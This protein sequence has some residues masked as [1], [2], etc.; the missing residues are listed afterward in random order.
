MSESYTVVAT[1]LG[2]LGLFLVAMELM[3]DG[4]TLAAG[5]SL[6]RLLSNWTNTLMRGVFSGVLMTAIVQ[7]SS[8]VTVASLGFVNA[9]LIKMRQALGI[10][11]GANIGTTMTAWLVAI[12]GFKLDVHAFALPAIGIGAFIM[13]A[14]SKGR[15]LG[16]G[17][18]L[19]GFGLFFLGIST[20][21]QAFEGIV[22]NFDLATITLAGNAEVAGYLLIGIV[23]TIL[24]QSSS[25]AIAITISAASANMIG[26]YAAAAMVIGANVGT[27]STAVLASIGATP[28]AKRLATAQVIFNIATAIVAV[29]LLPVLFYAVETA[30]DM[31]KLAPNIGVSL[32]LF[33]TVFN[34]LGV[35][36]VLP[37]NNVFVRFLEKRFV[38]VGESLAKPR[39]LDK[40]TAAAPMLAVNALIL[41][42]QR[43]AT[44]IGDAAKQTLD[45]EISN[46]DL[47]QKINAVH[48]LS[49][50]ISNFIVNLERASLSEEVT[51]QLSDLMRVDQYFMSCAVVLGTT[52]ETRTKLGRLPNFTLEQEV[53][54]YRDKSRDFLNSAISA[55]SELYFEKLENNYHTLKSE[56]DV[57]KQNLL[58]TGTRGLISLEQMSNAIDF[59]TEIKQLNEQWYKAVKILSR[60]EIDARNRDSGNSDSETAEQEKNA[61]TEENSQD[62]AVEQMPV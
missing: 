7:S 3:T 52:L 34:C 61:E 6:R 45:T 43:A 28:N 41:E 53:E 54:T 49:N 42:L 55:D 18:A 9:E 29:L 47:E 57:L 39:Y 35:L 13:L 20:L 10:I 37:F 50:V 56:R 48:Q 62:E 4:L 33:H 21:Q 22:A 14:K 19:V 44:H 40:T 15:R 25:A 1:L 12:V 16:V 8:A 27:T 36:L 23:M 46:H 11:Y 30:R 2:G 32:A 31:M 51:H 38:T 24:T 59:I 5:H 17:R 26:I 58:S 60:I